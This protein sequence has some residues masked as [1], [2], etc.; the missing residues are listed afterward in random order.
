MTVRLSKRYGFAASHRLHS[1]A[2]TDEENRETYGKCNNPYGH[3][4]NY[5]VE[6]TVRGTIDQV[7]GR[8]V[9]LVRLDDLAEREF[10]SPFRHRNLNEEVP[11]FRMTVPTTEN[12]AL[13]VDRRL[14]EAWPES[15]PKDG[16]CLEMVRIRETDRNICEISAKAEK[17]VLRAKQEP[18]T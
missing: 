16:P 12:L 3:G 14:R 17:D 9:D 7:T 6:L 13:E 11:A 4:H 2:L 15:F 5:E 10:L 1:S 8:V 18:G